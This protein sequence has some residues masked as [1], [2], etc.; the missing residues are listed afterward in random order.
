M[1]LAMR[2]DWSNFYDLARSGSRQDRQD[3]RCKRL[4]VCETI[5]ANA[6]HDHSETPPGKLLLEL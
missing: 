3:V 4:H 6:E 2:S 1:K 5:A